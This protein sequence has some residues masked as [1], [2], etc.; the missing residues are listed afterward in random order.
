MQVFFFPSTLHFFRFSFVAVPLCFQFAKPK[1]TPLLHDFVGSRTEQQ[2][3]CCHSVCFDLAPHIQNPSNHGAH[4]KVAIDSFLLESFRSLAQLPKLRLFLPAGVKIAAEDEISPTKNL[5]KLF[6]TQQNPIC[7]FNCI[8]NAILLQLLLSQLGYKIICEADY[9]YCLIL[10]NNGEK[11]LIFMNLR[12][13]LCFISSLFCGI[14]T[15]N[16]FP[17]IWGRC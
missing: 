15:E 1:H 13:V 5:Y 3:A 9:N 6:T 17:F 16:C 2:S 8:V 10:E 12:S 11:N 14:S 7:V 4:G